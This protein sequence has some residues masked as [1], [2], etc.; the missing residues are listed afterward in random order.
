[1]LEYIGWDFIRLIDY[2]WL[3]KKDDFKQAIRCNFDHFDNGILMLIGLLTFPS[4]II[5]LPIII[6][7]EKKYGVN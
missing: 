7:D 2:G 4:L 5:T 3:W 6:Y 1:M